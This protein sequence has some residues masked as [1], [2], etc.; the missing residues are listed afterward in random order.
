[1]PFIADDIHSMKEVSTEDMNEFYSYFSFFG[2]YSMVKEINDICNDELK[3]LLD[4]T[5]HDHLI[6]MFN[7]TVVDPG[8]LLKATNKHFFLYCALL[9]MMIDRI[10]NSKYLSEGDRKKFK[11]F[12]NNMFDKQPTYAFFNKMRNYLVHNK[13]Q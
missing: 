7:N 6:E 8:P 5:R 2:Y 10:E 3:Y 12:T 1:M 4:I 9:R 11:K 13:F